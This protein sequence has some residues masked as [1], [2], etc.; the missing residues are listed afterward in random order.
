[1]SPQSVKD[2]AI[3]YES[4]LNK[5]PDVL[6]DVAFT[7]ANRREHLAHRSFAIATREHIGQAYA[8]SGPPGKSSAAPYLVMVFTGQGAQWAQMGRDLLRTNAIFRRSIQVLDS[9]LQKAGV[10]ADWTVEEELGRP[11]RTSRVNEAKFSQP[12]CTA[13]QIALVDTLA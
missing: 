13:L 7:L 10:G 8:P 1:M 3:Q 11:A 6:S 4:F 9:H 12:L 5:K 2:M